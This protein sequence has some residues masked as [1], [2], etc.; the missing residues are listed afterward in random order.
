MHESMNNEDK[1]LLKNLRR[2]SVLYVEDE[3]YLRD[4]LAR[5][6]E[7]RIVDLTLAKNGREGLDKFQEISPDIVITDIRMPVMDGLEMSREIK[8]LRD[9]TPIII[10]TAHND[11]EFFLRAIDVGIDKYIKKPVDR[12]ELLKSLGDVA[13]SIIQQKELRAKNEMIRLIMDNSPEFILICDE[14][15]INYVNRS[16]LNFIGC[17]S[18]EEYQTG[19]Y[20]LESLIQYEHGEPFEEQAFCDTIHNYKSDRQILQIHPQNGEDPGEPRSFLLRVNSLPGHTETL[21]ILT[22]ITE[23][24]EQKKHYEELS[25]RDT[26]TG[27]FNRKKFNEELPARIQ[28]AEINQTPLSLIIIDIDF[29]KNVNDTY[30]HQAGDDV[31]KECV[32]TISDNIRK[33][34]FFARY[35]GEEFILIEPE[36]SLKDATR[37]AEKLRKTV[38]ETSF[39]HV[40]RLTCSFGVASLDRMESGESLINRADVALYRAKKNGRNRVE[41]ERGD[42]PLG[43]LPHSTEQ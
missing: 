28:L 22:D 20:R 26:L 30:G 25:N 41:V 32:Q 21:V 15:E 17:E 29:F 33:T 39:S 42:D 19:N 6:L 1:K 27:I 10:T 34:D 4:R 9:D 18:F 31:L 2:V 16:F 35:G 13:R 3:D 40:D 11:E 23:I 5:I 24:N 37:L 14:S 36:T 43:Q 12:N 7:R 8:R 38:E